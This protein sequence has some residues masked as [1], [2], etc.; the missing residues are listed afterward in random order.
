[1]A[2]LETVTLFRPVGQKELDLIAASG[3][4]AFPP[5]L[6]VQPIFYPVLNEEYAVEIARNWNTKDAQSGYVGYVTRFQV[7]ADFLSP[8]P[9]QTVGAR[10]H[11][12]YWIPAEE[13]DA[14]NRHIVGRMKSSG[15]SAQV[16]DKWL[17]RRSKGARSEQS[18]SSLP[19]VTLHRAPSRAICYAMTGLGTRWVSRLQ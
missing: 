11:Q 1:M 5:R 15:K 4:T 17:L 10:P 13:L 16:T 7:R 6:P 12:E 8:Y 2:S 9:V 3:F 18:G 19:C 14:F